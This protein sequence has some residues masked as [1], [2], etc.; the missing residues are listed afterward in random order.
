MINKI[1]N[2]INNDL[3]GIHSDEKIYSLTQT[4][5]YENASGNLI[6]GP[7]ILTGDDDIKYVGIDDIDSIIIYHKINNVQTRVL[8]N[9]RGDK[10][11]DVKNTYAMSLICFWKML[12][13]RLFPDE[14]L[15]LIQARTPNALLSIPNT[16]ACVFTGLNAILN[17]LQVY[18]VE[19]G[20]NSEYR[21]PTDMGMLQYNYQLELTLSQECLKKCVNC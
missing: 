9:G 12:K 7:I 21:L 5:V 18:A 8:Q 10:S 16:S 2:I 11:G 6:Q 14:M 4:I 3:K 17:P 1:L 19:Y 13:V 15:L 20:N